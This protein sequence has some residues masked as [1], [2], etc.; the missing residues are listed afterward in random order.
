MFLFFSCVTRINN[1]LIN[2]CQD[3]DIAMSIYNLTSYSKKYQNCYRDE[4]SNDAVGAINYLVRG[5]KS[6]SYKT[7]LG[8]KIRR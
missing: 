4:P 5:S 2:D 6:F 1:F 3:L 7:S 8:W